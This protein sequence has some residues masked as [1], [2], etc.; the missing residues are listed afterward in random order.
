MIKPYAFG[1]LLT[2]AAACASADVTVGTAQGSSCY[3]FQCKILSQGSDYAQI[4]SALA[5]PKPIKFNKITFF[6]SGSPTQI[7]AGTYEIR[8]GFTAEAVDVNPFHSYFSTNRDYFLGQLGGGVGTSFSIEGK[9]VFYDR[10]GLNLVMFVTQLDVAAA[11]IVGG[12]D[13]DIIGPVTTGRYAQNGVG[14]ATLSGGLVTEFSFDPNGP[15]LGDVPAPTALA[16]LA[17]LP[18]FLRRRIRLT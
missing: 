11:P 8:F 9:P 17:L 5:F 16:L 7:L 13:A 15:H 6:N 10:T 12:F 18:L 14:L 3:P 4:Y 2:I 1:F